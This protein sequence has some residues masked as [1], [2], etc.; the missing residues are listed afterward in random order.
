MKIPKR[1][2]QLIDRRASLACKLSKISSEVDN[3]IL[4]N[5]IVGIDESDYLYGSEIVTNP[6]AS[7][8]RVKEAINN[9]NI[10]EC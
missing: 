8:E 3:F 10:G 4:N 2:E 9:Y 6:Y 5:H 1:I 7:A